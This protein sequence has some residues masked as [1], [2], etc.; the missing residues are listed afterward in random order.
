MDNAGR[1]AEVT[2]VIL[3]SLYSWVCVVASEVFVY[4]S[5]SDTISI[6]G[7]NDKDGPMA[8]GAS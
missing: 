1:A 2:K 6:T 4:I 5:W 8:T 7:L 3:S